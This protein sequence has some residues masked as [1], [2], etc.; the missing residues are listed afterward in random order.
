MNTI[1][2]NKIS[3]L[4]ELALTEFLRVNDPKIVAEFQ[5]KISEV[6]HH[7]IL[8]VTDDKGNTQEFKVF[9]EKIVLKILDYM[10]FFKV[11]T[12]PLFY[13]TETNL[14]YQSAIIDFPN[15]IFNNPTFDDFCI[16]LSKT[17]F[18]EKGIAFPTKD[19]DI[20]ISYPHTIEP[21]N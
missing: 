21:T 6:G 1:D 15:K 17:L 20:L 13:D 9:E 16:E 3:K 11:D 2:E 12:Q 10:R 5:K 18:S 8:Q 7:I 14:A 4:R 19:Y